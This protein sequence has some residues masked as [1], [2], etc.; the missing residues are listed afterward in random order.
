MYGNLAESS[1]TAD[2][3]PKSTLRLISSE[4]DCS[5]EKLPV[6]TFTH[7]S[8]IIDVLPL[9]LLVVCAWLL[10]EFQG[11]WVSVDVSRYSVINISNCYVTTGHA[12]PRVD[13]RTN[14]FHIDNKLSRSCFVQIYMMKS[15]PFN[16]RKGK[17]IVFNIASSTLVLDLDVVNWWSKIDIVGSLD[18]STNRVQIGQGRSSNSNA[19]NSSTSQASRRFG[20]ISINAKLSLGLI[21]VG[22][23]VLFHDQQF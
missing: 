4:M 6:G 2:T 3:T 21:A 11:N 20:N 7:A 22:A 19:T 13:A 8:S 5:E 1:I 23:A 10:P 9:F 12:W 16:E 17:N 14:S 18:G 15:Q